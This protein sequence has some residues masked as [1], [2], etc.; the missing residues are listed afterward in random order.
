VGA[1]VASLAVALAAAAPRAA[2]QDIEVTARARGLALPPGYYARIR[3]DP[4]AFELRRGWIARAARAAALNASPLIASPLIASPLGARPVPRAGGPSRQQGVVGGTLPL[5]V[6]PALF[7]DSRAPGRAV[8]ASELGRVL[9]TGPSERGTLAGFY[10][11]GSR[12]RLRVSGV[13]APWARTSLTMSQVVAGS[14]GL[15][16][17]ARV[18]EYLVEALQEADASIDFR[19][20]DNDGPDGVPDSGDDDGYV[21]AAAFLF[22]ERAAS[23]GGPA[24]WPHRSVIRGWTGIPFATADTG[25][26]GEPIRVDDYIIQG[27]TECGGELMRPATI[28]HELGHVLG[29]PDLYDATAGLL[30]EQRRWVIGCWELMSAGSWGCGTSP[31]SGRPTHMGAWTAGRLG[32]RSPLVVGDVRDREFVLRPAISSGEVLRVPLSPRE[33]LELEYRRA[34]GF[35]G[36]LP[37]SGVLVYHVE[38][39]RPFH[40]CLACN[41]SYAVQ[42]V[43]A[44]ANG[45]L[46]R[47]QPEGGNRGEPGDAFAVRGAAALSNATTPGTRTNAGAV[48]T[49]TIHAIAV[50]AA[51]GVAR[52]RLTTS[53]APAVVADP[54]GA[55][56]FSPYAGAVRVA[57]GAL[58]YTWSVS[59]ALPAGLQATPGAESVAI[60]G[61]PL[62]M[63]SWP[64]QVRVTDA[65]G[66][67]ATGV[68]TLTVG[69]PLFAVE[70]LVQP[71]LATT[72]PPLT[73]P[74][75]AWLDDAGNRNGR[76]DVGDL[77]KW[78]R[79]RVTA[80]ER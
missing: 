7:A 39:G 12:G 25:A 80:S 65:L 36:D 4:D 64:L 43:E 74:E 21:D 15:G 51:A 55:A 2:A 61:T 53:A 10:A 30:P 28:A 14:M 78:L 47:T 46:V 35:D 3:R 56:L 38:T 29:Q 22:L 72:A 6:I 45:T 68:A 62:A 76:Y 44:D 63:G 58:P 70:R 48:T 40:P 60:S 8:R 13:V 41:G 71:F 77:R 26:S 16:G 57:G 19:R 23:C 59:G 54:A 18:G 75:R 32:W 17:D 79:G 50:D 11:E 66:T 34:E 33:Y 9:F 49:V 37:A 73:D 42:L 69:E 20:F 5:A 24:I 1:P 52:V 67:T 31:S 27:A